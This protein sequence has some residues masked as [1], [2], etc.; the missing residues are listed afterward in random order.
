MQ[1]ILRF[2]FVGVVV[3]VEII[4]IGILFCSNAIPTRD[5]IIIH[6]FLDQLYLK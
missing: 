3:V 4:I 1:T 2:E 5:L 6:T